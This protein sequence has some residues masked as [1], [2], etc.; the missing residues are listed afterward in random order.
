M[1]LMAAACGQSANPSGTAPG[2]GAKRSAPYTVRVQVWGDVQD[3]PVYDN[4]QADYNPAHA[5]IKI[6]ND[7]LAQ[8]QDYYQKFAA[9]LA[10]GTAADP[11]AAVMAIE[12]A[13]LAMQLAAQVRTK[14]VEALQEIFHTQI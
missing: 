6:E 2:S 7:H 8:G 5:D 12:R 10:A 1:G 11:S 14:G 3:K 13:R 9:N 4:I